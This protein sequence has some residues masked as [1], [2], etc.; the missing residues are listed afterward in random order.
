[1]KVQVFAKV[2]D[3]IVELNQ[4][5]LDKRQNPTFS[6]KMPRDGYWIS[7]WYVIEGREKLP[8]EAPNPN[9]KLHKGDTIAVA[10]TFDEVKSRYA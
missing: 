6:Y 7:W 2:D 3:E 10:H 8:Y 4:V 5:D 1:M 9:S